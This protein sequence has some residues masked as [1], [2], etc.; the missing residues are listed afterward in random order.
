MSRRKRRKTNRPPQQRRDKPRPKYILDII[1]PIFGEFALAQEALSRVQAACSPIQG[2]EYRITVLDNGTPDW[3]SSEDGTRVTPK[4]MAEPVKS[5]LRNHDQFIRLEENIGYPGG[6]NEAVFKASSGAP[7]VLILT[8]DVFMEPG[9][10]NEMVRAMD[11]QELGVC[12]PKLLF[13][14]NMESPHGPGGT[15]QHAGIAFNIAGK[16]YHIFIGWSPTNPKVNIRREVAAVTGACFMTRRDLWD[17]I[18]GFDRRYGLGTFEDI[19]YCFAVRA[20]GKKVMYIPEA[21]GYHL[22]NGARLQGAN[23]SGF[24]LPM[25]ETIFRGKWAY[26]LAWDEWRY[27]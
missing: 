3:V 17:Q 11:N 13:P 9:S 4:E 25:N 20:G 12:G 23:A 2:H 15:I 6:C 16:P 1:I 21:V 22:V 27:L 26:M 5:L 10:I 19:D 14:L 8:A 7:L 24:N 18:G